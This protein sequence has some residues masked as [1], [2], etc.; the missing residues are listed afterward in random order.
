MELD[1]ILQTNRID[2]GKPEILFSTLQ[3]LLTTL[4]DMIFVKDINLVYVASTD[5]FAAMTGHSSVTDII[6]RTDEEIFESRELAMRYV[7]DDR[8]LLSGGKHLID[9]VEP[10]TDKDGTP[11]YSATSKYIL[12]NGDGV[13]VGLLG[14]SRD[15]TNKVRARQQ[16]QQEIEYLFN[17]PADA[18]AAVF[19]DVTDWR[20]IGQRRQVIHQY[21]V[22]L[23]DTLSHFINIAETGVVDAD[24]EAYQFYRDFTEEALSSIY[25]KGK[26][27]LSMEYLRR[28]SDGNSYWVR[29]EIKFMS[30]PEND[31]LCLM[32]VIRDVDSAH[33]DEEQLRRAAETDGMTG[34]LNRAASRQ[35]IQAFLSGEGSN[36]KHAT[37]MIDIDNFKA[38]NDNFGHREGDLLLTRLAEGIRACF[39][40]SDII[41]RIGGDEFF[42]LAKH[43][44]SHD[45]AKARADKL[46]SLAQDICAPYASVSTSISI[47]VSL[48]QEDGDT[49]TD[50]YV[51]A[52]GALYLA[53]NRGKNQVAFASELQQADT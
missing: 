36:G 12:K 40:D 22:P 52:D 51:K 38:V 35:K 15:V 42:V 53:K 14:I 41:S 1:E 11:R 13:P 50:L 46:L 37:F 21:E 7:A 3:M 29:D 8:K 43:M 28:M 23:F 44:S 20:I 39:R 31:H 48:F 25:L 5:S 24:G 17:L 2:S 47:G 34:L 4:P 16:Y 32:L 6:G 33:K 45:A 26:S 18:Y 27:G 10:L 19:I 49:L 9:Y 30:D